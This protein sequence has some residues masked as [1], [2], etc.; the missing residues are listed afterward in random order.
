MVM[1]MFFI[2]LEI[3]LLTPSNVHVRINDK[4]LTMEVDTGAALSII[5]EKTRKAVF[6]DEKL[7]PS[8]L[9]LKTYTNEPLKVMG[10]LNVQVQYEDQLKKLVLVVVYSWQWTELTWQK[11]AKPY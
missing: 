4:Q 6:P 8:K 9:V 1:N 3:V 2:G 5:S 10:T 11:L 7:R